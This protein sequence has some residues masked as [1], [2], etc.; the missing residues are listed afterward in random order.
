MNELEEEEQSV[1][2]HASGIALRTR[3]AAWAARG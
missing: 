1:V 3:N 2:M